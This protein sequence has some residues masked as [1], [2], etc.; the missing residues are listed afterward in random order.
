M[1]PDGTIQEYEIV[2]DPR[3]DRRQVLTE[4]QLLRMI[5]EAGRSPVERDGRYRV[6]Q[7]WDSG[8]KRGA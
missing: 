8:V 3:T 2:R 1:M 5:R 6:V 7:V 4:A